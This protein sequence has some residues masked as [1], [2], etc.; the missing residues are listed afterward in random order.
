MV[1]KVT[2]GAVGA[3]SETSLMNAQPRI[4]PRSMTNNNV[5]VNCSIAETAKSFGS[6]SINTTSNLP[7]T[8]KF[9][10]AYT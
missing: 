9:S 7:H 10:E 8:T 6:S 1:Q 3:G 5:A 2:N 4:L